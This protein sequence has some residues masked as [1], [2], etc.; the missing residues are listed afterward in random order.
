MCPL[1]NGIDP[2]LPVLVVG[3]LANLE[4]HPTAK[5]SDDLNRHRAINLRL[6]AF[7]AMD[8]W[9]RTVAT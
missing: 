4:R 3:A 1:L 8:A 7:G 2:D 5:M 6:R 9:R